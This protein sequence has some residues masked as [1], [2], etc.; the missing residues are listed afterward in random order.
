MVF[1]ANF[2]IFTSLVLGIWEKSH[3]NPKLKRPA[4]AQLLRSL[5]RGL[6]WPEVT[7][8]RQLEGFN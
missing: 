3:V 8:E 1:N 6:V 4:L 2:G 7:S 5:A